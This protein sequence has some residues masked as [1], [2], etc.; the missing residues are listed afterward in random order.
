LIELI[1]EG[2]LRL[3]MLI[4][5]IYLIGR[6]RDIQRVFA[7]HGAEHRTI[8]AYEHGR[9][10]MPANVR[11]YPNAHPR[12]GTAFLLTVAVLS[13]IVFVAL[14]TP[15]LWVR[16]VERV[17]L[18]PVIASI[19]YELLRLGQRFED[20]AFVS[21]LYRPNLWLQSLTTR[22]PDD[23]QIEVAIA[24]LNAAL[25]VE[26]AVDADR[27]RETADEPLA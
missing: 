25:A 1:A 19:A 22:D 18:I 26:S 13:L 21:A 17:V 14:G 16:A 5:Y 3:G 27:D 4:G 15:P 20:N 10:L 6:V 9:A 23:T 12:C 11:E 8:H 2:V 24:A 7:Y